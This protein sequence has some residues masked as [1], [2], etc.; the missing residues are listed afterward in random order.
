MRIW[1][2][3]LLIFTSVLVTGNLKSDDRLN[4]AENVSYLSPMEKEIVYEIN[5]FRTNPAKYAIDYIAPLAKYYENNVLHYPDD[6][7]IITIEGIKALEECVKELK[8]ETPKAIMQ[9]SLSL[10]MSAFDHQKDQSKTGK[11]GHTGNDRSGFKQRIERYGKWQVRIAENIAYG[12]SS[13]RQVII[14]L[15]ID[16]NVKNR[17]HRKNLLHPSFNTVGV[18]FGQHPVF[19]TMCVMEFAGGML[20]KEN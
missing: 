8:G 1:L 18:S 20:E 7:P 10:S 11:T 2:T 3:A 4:T 12:N 19:K 15:L 13:A 17:G 16:D 14:F 6:T 9:P 5:L